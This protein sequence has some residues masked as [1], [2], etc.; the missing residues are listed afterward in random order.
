MSWDPENI[1]EKALKCDIKQVLFEYFGELY[2]HSHEKKA[3]LV[4]EQRNI[5]NFSSGEFII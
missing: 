5:Q 3:N 1:L 4:F 2:K